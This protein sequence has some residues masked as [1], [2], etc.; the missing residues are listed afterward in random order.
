[1]GMTRAMYIWLGIQLV[2]Q[3][4]MDRRTLLWPPHPPLTPM[5]FLTEKKNE[6]MHS[7]EGQ[8]ASRP[9]HPP[10]TRTRFL[11]EEKTKGVHP[12]EGK[13]HDT[14]AHRANNEEHT[15]TLSPPSHCL[16][17]AATSWQTLGR[18]E[19]SRGKGNKG[20][21]PGGHQGAPQW[22]ADRSVHM[23]KAP[24]GTLIQA[25]VTRSGATVDKFIKDI[26]D[27]VCIEV[28]THQRFIVRLDV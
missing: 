11:T 22:G 24:R 17:C 27:E 16:R 5:G 18:G 21:Q 9:S 2:W 14:R 15:E 10:L 7:H 6:G 12:R 3:E 1:M 28:N 13:P 4:V 26:L 19:E 20:A 23:V 8:T 25:I